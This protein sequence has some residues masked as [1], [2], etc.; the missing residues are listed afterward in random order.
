[1]QTQCRG[2]TTTVEVYKGTS[3]PTKAKGTIVSTKLNGTSIPTNTDRRSLETKLM[4]SK[5]EIY[6]TTVR[7]IL[8]TTVCWFEFILSGGDNFNIHIYVY[9]HI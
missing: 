2:A 5:I 6:R 1:M 4:T 7:K 8:S 3:M 9:I